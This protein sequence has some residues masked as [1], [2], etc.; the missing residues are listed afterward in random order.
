MLS[1]QGK[2]SEKFTGSL[3]FGASRYGR[4]WE[5]V[6][7]VGTGLDIPDL[8][9]IENTTAVTTSYDLVRKK[10]QSVYST[11]QLAY[12]N[13]LFLD[14]NARNDWSST[15]GV[16][17]QSYFYPA[18]SLSGVIT[19]AFNIQSDV[20]SFAK[21]RASY[22]QAGN[23]TQPY[24][25]TAGYN[26]ETNYFKG[27]RYGSIKGALPPVDLK[28]ELKTSY[29]FG[30]DFRLLKNRIGIDFTYYNS[31]T[32]NQIFDVQ[33]SS[34]SGYGSLRG[35]AGKMSNKGIELFV[36][37]VPVE[38]PNSLKWEMS[39]NFSKNKSR[40][41]SLAEG[42]ET[43]TILSN[44]NARIEARPGHPYGDIIGHING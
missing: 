36:T 27:I 33:I 17:N 32:T 29:E 15:L 26:V 28:N 23:D 40:V 24:Q 20:L 19:D 22:A 25:T 5:K 37:V 39:L 16:N 13:Y 38:I 30:A 35:N 10:I 4:R 12:K 43:Y 8:Y 21:V 42:L 2:L 1:A 7:Q 3:S 11:G 14:L 18:V 31:N 34:A 44:G 41:V 6:D 9:I